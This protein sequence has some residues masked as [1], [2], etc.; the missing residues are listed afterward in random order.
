MAMGGSMVAG[1]DDVTAGYW[2]PA[3]L[4]LIGNDMQVGLM[5]AGILR[6]S[7]SMTMEVWLFRCSRKM[8]YWHFH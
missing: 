8:P 2:N 6:A 1:V 7:P 3:G 5:H 4:L